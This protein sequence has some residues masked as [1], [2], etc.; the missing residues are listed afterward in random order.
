MVPAFRQIP[1]PLQKQ[2]LI[3]LGLG[4]LFFLL[5]IVLLFAWQD[6]RL[7]LPSAGAAVFFAVIAFSLFCRAARDDYVLVRGECREVIVTPVRRRVKYLIL[8]SDGNSIRVVFH[9]R[10][11]KITVGTA[12]DLY[13]AKNTP[14]FEKDGML[15]LYHYLAME[16]KGRQESH[17][18]Q[19]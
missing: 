12:V 10:A 3:R 16:I 4:A 2:I 17:V 18:H 5:L 8:Q 9:G 1:N 14:I 11:R 19:G 13:L 6:V 15:V 7:W